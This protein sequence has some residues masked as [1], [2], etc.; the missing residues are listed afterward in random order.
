MATAFMKDTDFL[1][2][3][4]SF[5]GKSKYVKGGYGQLLTSSFL[6]KHK[7]DSWFKEKSKQNSSM[8]NYEYLM[9]F[10]DQGWYCT[11]CVCLLK[12]VLWGFDGNGH[13]GSVGANGVADSTDK[14]FYDMCY[15]KID[16]SGGKN[17][18]KL[19]PGM[20]LYTDTPS[21]HV[22]TV[23]KVDGKNSVV[24]ESAPSTDGT[25][26]TSITYQNWKGAGYSPY[27]IYT[28]DVNPA[29]APV[30]PITVGS[31]V[32]IVEG[33]VYGGSAKGT[34]VPKEYIGKPYTVSKV[35]V[36][37]STQEALIEELYSWVPTK[38][39]V[40][41]N[42]ITVGSTVTIISGAVYG[43]S[44]YGVK[45]PS[46]CIGVPY[47]VSKIEKHNNEDE[48]LLKEI[49]SW[50][51]LKY[52]KLYTASEKPKYPTKTVWVDNLNVRTGPSTNYTVVKLVHKGT[53]FTVYE[54]KGEWSRVGKNEW[55]YSKYIK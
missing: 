25:A 37:N 54:T 17:Y 38:Y 34:P 39:L 3:C 20:I 42:S 11:D 33:A 22:G 30:Q 21:G 7:K 6:N 18:D 28:Q 43:G 50:V 1:N 31:I 26:N 19:K 16:I 55:V 47:T 13:T 32:K 24:I 46:D 4:E 9:Q 49:Y 23:W 52:L 27:I 8:T 51:A 48:A 29:P 12:G 45:V 14:Q 36:H 5:V 41:V 15:G 10:A 44:A 53:K 2:G 40:L 35:E